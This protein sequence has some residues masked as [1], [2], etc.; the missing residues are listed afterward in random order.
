MKEFF[1]LVETFQLREL[2]E[3]FLLDSLEFNV[4]E[5]RH[6]DKFNITRE[7]TVFHMIAIELMNNFKSL[8]YI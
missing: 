3:N 2:E 4:V 7:L 6:H 5:N 8:C 1:R